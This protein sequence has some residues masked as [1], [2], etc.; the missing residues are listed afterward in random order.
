[1]EKWWVGYVEKVK[2]DINGKIQRKMMKKWKNQT[3]KF[4]EF[5]K[6]VMQ[7]KDC[8][9]IENGKKNDEKV[10]PKNVEIVEWW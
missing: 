8:E 9:K 7:L 10:K 3:A 2:K 5:E 1:M 6:I 4:W